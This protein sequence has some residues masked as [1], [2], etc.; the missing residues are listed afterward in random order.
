MKII[1]NII[2]ILT[3]S[4]ILYTAYILLKK[5]RS[6]YILR[7]FFA[8]IIFYILAV[9]L[10]LK[11]TVS[12]FQAFVSFFIIIL[13]VLFQKEIRR[14]FENF[15]ISFIYN[16]INETVPID[17]SIVNSVSSAIEY[18]SKKKI[19]AIV[20]LTG[21]QNLE[22]ILEG[23]IIL[24]GKISD[25]LLISIFNP[26]TP[27]HDGA[28]IIEGDQVKK[29]AVHLPLADNYKKYPNLGTRHRAGLGVAERTDAMTI[30]VSEERGTI[31]IGINDELK[32]VSNSEKLKIEI[33]KFIGIENKKNEKKDMKEKIKMI[34]RENKNDK[35]LVLA[36]SIFLWYIIVYK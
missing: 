5:T 19:G 22:R 10:D 3:T 18:L 26:K 12:L 16:S 6:I 27:G 33:Q 30:I 17:N 24:N 14:F 1:T 8:L 32:V 34:L 25:A 13:V 7:G 11:L 4:F 28:I 29:F 20:V 36:I 15:S 31:T 9:F 35:L 21:K 2:D 23:G